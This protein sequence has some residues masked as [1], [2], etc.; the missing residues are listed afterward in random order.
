ME[1]MLGVISKDFIGAHGLPMLGPC[2]HGEGHRRCRRTY[3]WDEAPLEDVVS[4]YAWA[5]C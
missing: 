4:E 1:R 5:L 3:L 2:G